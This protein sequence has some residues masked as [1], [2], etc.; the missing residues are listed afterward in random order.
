MGRHTVVGL[1]LFGHMLKSWI[2]C[3]R[4]WSH[5]FS[6]KLSSWISYCLNLQ[7]LPAHCG[8]KDLPSSLLLS[9]VRTDTF[10]WCCRKQHTLAP[11]HR[12]IC[13][14]SSFAVTKYEAKTLTY[15]G[16]KRHKRILQFWSLICVSVDNAVTPH[17]LARLSRLVG[18]NWCPARTF[19]ESLCSVH[20]ST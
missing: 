10:G 16:F 19:W 4:V 12:L 5:I 15:S 18:Y 14:L 3:N 6:D 9:P 7:R 1:K 11:S 13:W 17:E 8:E 2:H 20:E